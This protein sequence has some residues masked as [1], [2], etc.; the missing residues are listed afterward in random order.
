MEERI[1][2]EQ[3]HQSTGFKVFLASAMEDNHIKHLIQLAQDPSLI[4]L[5]G[6]DTFFEL[7]DTEEFIQAISVYTLSYS[8][9]SQ[10]LLCG[11]YLEPEELPIGYVVLKGFNLD[12]LTAEIAVA[13]LDKRYRNKG[14]GK[15]A[16]NRLI[17]YGFNELQIQTIAA[18]IL[19]L[20]HKSTNMVKNLGFVVREIMYNSWPMPDGKLVDMQWMEVTRETWTPVNSRSKGSRERKRKR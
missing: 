6:W 4:D 20:N 8:R 1:F 10:P 11:V 5:L 16:L 3:E 12:L 13:I 18:T 2:L 17:S 19:L 14:Y 7:D 9:E 15:L